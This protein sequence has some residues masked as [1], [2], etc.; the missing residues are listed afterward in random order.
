VKAAR[1]NKMDPDPPRWVTLKGRTH[2][3]IQDRLDAITRWACK[4]L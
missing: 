3:S 1:V 2:P 4:T